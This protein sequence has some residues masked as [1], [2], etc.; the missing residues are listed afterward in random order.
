MSFKAFSANRMSAK[1]SLGVFQ[2]LQATQAAQGAIQVRG[3]LGIFIQEPQK[4]LFQ[5]LKIP[6]L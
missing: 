4:V 1:Q 5:G 3:R 6:E 2:I